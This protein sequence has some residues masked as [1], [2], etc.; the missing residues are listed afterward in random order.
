MLVG[1]FKASWNHKTQEGT[2]TLVGITPPSITPGSQSIEHLNAAE[3]A[4]LIAILSATEPVEY[5]S[6]SGVMSMKNAKVIKVN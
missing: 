2:L 5:S 3:M 4:A 6:A 1:N